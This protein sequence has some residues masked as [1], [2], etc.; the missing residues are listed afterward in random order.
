[1]RD[2]RGAL[3]LWVALAILLV[4]LGGVT[5]VVLKSLQPEKGTYRADVVIKEIWAT[6]L[7]LVEHGPIPALDM[8]KAM[9]MAFFVESPKMLE[10]AKPGDRYRIILKETP[11]KLL[12]VKMVPIKS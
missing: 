6:D 10:G 3:K 4:A 9:S 5:W 12:I 7:V 2:A 11:G 8:N 1:M